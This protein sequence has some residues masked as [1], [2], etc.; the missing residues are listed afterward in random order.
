MFR[1]RWRLTIVALR[2]RMRVFAD[3][4]CI[5]L[6]LTVEDDLVLVLTLAR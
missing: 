2:A 4:V 1:P 6:R 3:V 5:R